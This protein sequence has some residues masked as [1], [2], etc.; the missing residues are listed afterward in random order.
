MNAV[1]TGVRWP[2]LLA[3]GV[4]L[5]AI[6]CTERA[7]L[8]VDSETAPGQSTPTTEIEIPVQGMISWRDTTYTGY[9]VPLTS[10]YRVVNDSA[11][12]TSRLLARFETI[13]DSIDVG[14]IQQPIEAYSSGRFRLLVDTA[15]SVI[16]EAGLELEV[17]ALTRAYEERDATWSL[18]ALDEPWTEPGGDLGDRIGALR[19][20][21]PFDSTTSDTLFVPFE[22]STDSVLSNWASSDGEPGLA[23]RAVGA[24]SSVDVRA[25]AVTFEVKP[26]GQDS[27]VPAARSP[28]GYTVIF[29][30]ETPPPG[31]ESRIGGLPSSRIYLDFELP[32]TWEGLQLKGS[33]INAA[34]LIF[35]PVAPPPVPFRL[36]DPLE[37]ISYQ[38]L[39]DPFEVGPKTPIGGVLGPP[40]LLDPEDLTEDDAEL[41][42]SI[43]PLVLIWSFAPADSL[44][45]LR[46]GVQASPEGRSLGF[47]EF[48]SAEDVTSLQPS[49]R[50]LVTPRVPFRLP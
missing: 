50:M 28:A 25:L 27:L 24:G 29:D 40:D 26:V 20:D 33:T 42:L 36:E 45:V 44:D 19:I 10:P 8:E 48:G 39:A 3:A 46:I 4:S 13:P 30:P 6:G 21:A 32:E 15:T 5:V 37:V 2:I 23:I 34:S 38:L 43:T 18:A 12:V 47:W 49:V 7:V 41:Q 9:V 17:F 11:D 22:V 16:P 31:Q 14:T 35:R 1:R